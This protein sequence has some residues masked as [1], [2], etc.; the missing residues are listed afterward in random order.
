MDRRKKACSNEKCEFYKEKKYDSSFSYCPY[1][2]TKLVYVCKSIKCFKPIE[3]TVPKHLYCEECLAKQ[4]DAKDSIKRGA[5]KIGAA[6]CATALTLGQKEAK[7]M[8][9]KGF[10]IAKK[11]IN[12]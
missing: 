2:S 3:D 9:K 6:A 11:A 8:V 4:K 1:C 10:S 5:K 12:K 7:E